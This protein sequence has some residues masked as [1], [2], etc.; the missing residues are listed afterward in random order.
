MEPPVPAPPAP[1]AKASWAD[2]VQKSKA[3]VPPAALHAALSPA[4]QHVPRPLEQSSQLPSR[5][6]SGP[7]PLA[8]NQEKQQEK[9]GDK[10]GQ[11]ERAAPE[12]AVP[13]GAVNEREPSKRAPPIV[14]SGFPSRGFGGPQQRLPVPAAG[15]PPPHPWFPPAFSHALTLPFVVL[16]Q[17]FM[18]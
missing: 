18:N 6:S 8:H 15:L 1:P 2:I 7:Q 13:E 10:V 12:R 11:E 4:E 3:A 9:Q 17:P 16:L 14:L 5:G